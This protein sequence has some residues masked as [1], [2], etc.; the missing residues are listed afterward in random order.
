MHKKGLAVIYNS[1]NLLE[2]IWYYS[3]G[4]AD[5]EWDALC[6]PSGSRGEYISE[7]CKRSGIFQEVISNN[8]VFAYSSLKTQSTILIK[9]IS[10][11]VTGRKRR[12]CKEFADQFVNSDQY[13]EIVVLNDFDLVD[14]SFI[15]MAGSKKVIILEDGTADYLDRKRSNIFHN[16]FSAYEWK[17]LLLSCMGY[18]NTAHN[19]P[20]KLTKKCIKYSSHIDKL[21]YKEYKSIK[22][23]FDYSITDME[24][25]KRIITNTYDSIDEN[26]FVDIDTVLFTS[27]LSIFTKYMRA[28]TKKTIE[29]VSGIS[30]SVLIKKHPMDDEKYAFNDGVAAREYNPE[31]PA[32]VLLPFIRNKRLIFTFP[33]SLLLYTDTD[34]YDIECIFYVDMYKQSLKENT[35]FVY[36]DKSE[37]M[38]YLHIAQTDNIKIIDL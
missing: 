34:N 27:S 10:Y 2:F 13:D 15:G 8:T 20:L 14:C 32:E 1:H 28:Y 29:Y 31:I 3:S 35:N 33:S 7:Y 23:I 18:A 19:Y 5:K 36:P 9:M 12:Y 22:Q 25:Y 6:L 17:G 30:S 26:D 16:M 21:K 37:W 38:N 24:L 4:H 11:L